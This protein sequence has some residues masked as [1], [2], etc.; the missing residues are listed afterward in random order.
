MT[1]AKMG[2]DYFFAVIC[3][4]SRKP[5][6]KAWFNST[7]FVV[8]IG[9]IIP[10]LLPH[11]LYKLIDYWLKTIKRNFKRKKNSSYNASLVP[12]SVSSLPLIPTWVGS[13]QKTISALPH[14]LDKL[15]RR[16]TTSG[17]SVFSPSSAFITDKESVYIMYRI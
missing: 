12:L 7:Q 10:G 16:L 14:N 8:S 3:T 17:L 4:Q 9:W 5:F 6:S 2:Q 1:N 15:S 11:I 13:K